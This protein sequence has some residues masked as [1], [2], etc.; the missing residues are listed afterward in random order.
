MIV[1]H[2]KCKFLY[3]MHYLLGRSGIAWT[4]P[5]K[6]KLPNGDIYLELLEH[7]GP[8]VI[9]IADS[10]PVCTS[11]LHRWKFRH[12][13]THVCP[14]SPGHVS[15][16]LGNVF[17]PSNTGANTHYDQ[18]DGKCLWVFILRLRQDLSINYY[19]I[20]NVFSKTS[21][22]GMFNASSKCRCHILRNIHITGFRIVSFL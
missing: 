17:D 18:R 2:K 11:F 7:S 22:M 20:L 1:W 5:Q 9:C 14:I 10:S 6:Q 4:F 12:R 15:T 19:F 13:K 16:I 3:D 8:V 21:N